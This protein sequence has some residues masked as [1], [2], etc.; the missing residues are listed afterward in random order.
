M[1]SLETDSLVKQNQIKTEPQIKIELDEEFEHLNYLSQRR[2]FRSSVFTIKG[3]NYLAVLEPKP[4]AEPLT[5]FPST[6]TEATLSVSIEKTSKHSHTDAPIEGQS[7]EETNQQSNANNSEHSAIK[8]EPQLK[9]E[10]DAAYVNVGQAHQIFF[11]SSVS[12]NEHEEKI[13]EL[14]PHVTKGSPDFERKRP[15]PLKFG[16]R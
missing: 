8:L 13:I 4:K 6:S 10:I 5:N 11:S 16:A 2:L 15:F 7:Q 12:E 3:Q 1:N 14:I 9:I